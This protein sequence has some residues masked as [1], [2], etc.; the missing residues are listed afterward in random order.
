MKKHIFLYMKYFDIGIEDICYCEACGRGGRVDKG[1]F[2]I[3]H[4]IYKSQGGK[5]EIDNLI[6][7]C[8]RCHDMAHNGEL[9]KDNLILIHR[10]KMG[11]KP[12]YKKK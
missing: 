11:G 12:I 4:I 7:L 6:L 5:D 9:N 2:D 8:R 3:H 1:G 10:Y